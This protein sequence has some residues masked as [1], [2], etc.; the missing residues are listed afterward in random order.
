MFIRRRRVCKFT[1]QFSKKSM[2][3]SRRSGTVLYYFPVRMAS[4]LIYV[5]AVR[6][7]HNAPIVVRNLRAQ[8]EL[9]TGLLVFVSKTRRLSTITAGKHYDMIIWNCPWLSNYR[10][11]VNCWPRSTV[12]LDHNI[13]AI[14]AEDAKSRHIA[15]GLRFYQRCP[16]QSLCFTTNDSR[17]QTLV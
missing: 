1:Y 7:S 10:P 13:Q 4:A 15:P 6:G 5:S 16:A 3:S 12:D 17:N 8:G 11:S 14:G 2:K 9:R